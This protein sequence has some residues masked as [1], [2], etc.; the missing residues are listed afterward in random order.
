APL[1]HCLPAKPQ[2]PPDATSVRGVRV[3]T[4][5]DIHDANG[6]PV[7]VAAVSYCVDGGGTFSFALDDDSNVV[8]A[9]STA[10]GDDVGVIGARSSAR[11]ARKQ[12]PRLKN[13][14]SS[15]KTDVYR[16]D[17]GRQLVLGMAAGRV[18]FVA[19]AD[20]LLLE[21]PNKLGYYLHRLGY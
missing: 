15:G 6:N 10:D 3:G 1:P 14:R 20:R 13:L 18:T 4:K 2:P 17:S 16:V 5:A 7:K 19:A 11:A 21:Y 8:L 12:F 9:L